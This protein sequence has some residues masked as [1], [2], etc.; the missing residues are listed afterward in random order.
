MDKPPDVHRFERFSGLFDWFRLTTDKS[1]YAPICVSG[2]NRIQSVVLL[3][4]TRNV[5]RRIFC[6]VQTISPL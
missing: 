1:S 5:C 4:R 2:L 3:T 6:Q